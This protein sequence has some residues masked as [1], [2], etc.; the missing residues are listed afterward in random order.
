[1]RLSL[2]QALRQSSLASSNNRTGDELKMHVIEF[3][4]D[5]RDLSSQSILREALEEALFVWLWPS[6]V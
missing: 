6:V 4:G 3:G 2:Y 1:M 5:P